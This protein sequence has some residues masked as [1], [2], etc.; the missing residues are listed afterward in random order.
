MAFSENV[1]SEVFVRQKGRCALC[2]DGL[3]ELLEDTAMQAIHFHHIHPKSADGDDSAW[4]CVA[5][6]SDRY[7]AKGASSK[8]G[9]HYRVHADGRYK[10][11]FVADREMF[12]FSHGHED[13]VHEA[14]VY[15]GK[16][17]K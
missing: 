12:V 5:L 4:N 8:D 17:S 9:C 2:G 1:K 3:N 13:A 6:C 14:W 10:S 11:G 16:P 7:P 15:D